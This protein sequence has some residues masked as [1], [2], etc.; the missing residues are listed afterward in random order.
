MVEKDLLK[1][2]VESIQCLDESQVNGSVKIAID[3]GIAIARLINDG[4]TA[5]LRKLGERFESGEVFLPELM[6]GAMIVQQNMK[7]LETHIEKDEI[8]TKGKFMIGTVA[9]DIHDVGKNI[10]ATI[11]SASGYEVTDLGIDV[12]T[13]TFVAKIK[14]KKPQILG[15]SSLLT[16]TMANQRV[17]IE[18]LEAEGLRKGLKIIIGGAPASPAWAEKIHADAYA[19]DAFSGLREAEKFLG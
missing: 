17:V 12:S 10:V 18:A 19:E 3:Q 8:Q 4:L 13:E 14:E 2:L 15:L 1:T 7:E 6:K 5:G 11:F 9:N 16:T